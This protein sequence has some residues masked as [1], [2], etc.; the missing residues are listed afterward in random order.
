LRKKLQK[1]Q[2]SKKKN[3]SP[4]VTENKPKN[5]WILIREKK[6]KKEC[7]RRYVEETK[8]RQTK[9]RITK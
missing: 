2:R 9:E 4:F 7:L 5:K 6:K 3:I 8:G 1:K